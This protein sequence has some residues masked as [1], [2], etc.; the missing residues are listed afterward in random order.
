M[1]LILAFTIFAAVGQWLFFPATT[2]AHPAS[3]IVVDSAL[4]IYFSDLETIWKFD[5]QGKLT[6]FRTGERGRHV[7][8]LAI[9]EHDNVYGADVSYNPATEGW[10]SDVWKMTPEGKFTYLLNPTEHPPRGWSI[11]RDG[12][13]HMYFID[14]NNHTKRE[15]LLL[16]RSP[17]GTVT[18]FAGGAYGHAD[19][20]GNLAKFG[21]VG[22]MAFGAD[23]SLHLTDG[24]F[25][26]RVTMDG[27]VTTLASDL[28]ART[29]EDQPRLFAGSS[30]SLAGL[31]V[32]SG[33]NVYVADAGNRRL[34][35]VNK[36][37]GVQVIL[38]SEPPYFPTGVAAAGGNLYVLEVGFTLPNVSSGQRI[39]K[40][41][42]DGKA[43]I[44]A[45]VGAE[46]R[47]ADVGPSLSTRAGVVAESTLAFFYYGGRVKYSLTFITVGLVSLL[48]LIWQGR[49]R[50]R[51]WKRL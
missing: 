24:E 9:D 22:G 46:G 51:A 36:E 13:G 18:T 20:R 42:G 33:G 39:K 37:G 43:T 5:T 29:S 49:R 14:Q 11:W 40:I 4:N 1:K 47:N 17:D 6:V 50:L 48:A 10:I 21:S 3:G 32:D 26:R 7:H 23:G 19:G 8:E 16:R 27:T 38:R 2:E 31:D 12:A 41:D 25:L 28:L 35:K 30:G 44:L 15:T 45:T 34:L